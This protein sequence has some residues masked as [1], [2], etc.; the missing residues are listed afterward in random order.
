MVNSIQR[1]TQS[2]PFFPKSGHFSGFQKEQGRSHLRSVS[3]AYAWYLWKGLNK[4]FWTCQG[5][6]YAWSS[7]IINRL[8]QMPRVLNNPGFWTWHGCICKGYAEFRICLIM[9]LYIS[10]IPE[11]ALICLKVGPL[12]S[13]K[14]VFFA[15][16][17]TL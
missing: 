8:L 15:S 2:G 14:I 12:P 4:L 13:K 9:A 3:V 1:W 11:D 7:H 17:K 5:S 10:I 16:L 6:E